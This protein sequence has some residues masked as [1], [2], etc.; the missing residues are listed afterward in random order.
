LIVGFGNPLRGDDAL[1]P[2]VAEHL[3]AQLH[4]PAIQIL[5]PQALTPELAADLA[6]VELA[7]FI[8]AARE[9]RTGQVDC[10]RVEPAGDVSPSRIAHRLDVAMLL[11]WSRQLYGTAPPTY[12]LTTRAVSLSM[13]DRQL[14]PAVQKTVPEFIRRIEELLPAVDS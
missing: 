10:R 4:S 12:L 8:D 11:T 9:G 14:T 1:G 2:I 7:L 13:K 6:Q 3:R 5:T